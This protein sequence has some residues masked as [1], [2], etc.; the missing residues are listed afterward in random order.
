[1]RE[2]LLSGYC[3]ERCQAG[4]DDASVDQLILGSVL[5]WYCLMVVRGPRSSLLP[6]PHP[7]F[8]MSPDNR[9]C[10]GGVLSPVW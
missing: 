1:M 3:P 4:P 8:W 6:K 10:S 7:L 9:S 5:F 2:K